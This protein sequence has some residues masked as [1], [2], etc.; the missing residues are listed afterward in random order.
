MRLP[1]LGGKYA[2]QKYC[3]LTHH[4][5]HLENILLLETQT[6][7]TESQRYWQYIIDSKRY[8]VPDCLGFVPVI[9]DFGIANR[10]EMC[11]NESFTHVHPIEENDRV[12]ADVMHFLSILKEMRDLGEISIPDTSWSRYATLLR[13]KTFSLALAIPFLFERQFLRKPPADAVQM[14]QRMI[15]M[16][17]I[18]PSDHSL[19]TFFLR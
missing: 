17:S 11:T 8:Y 19:A 12:C 10:P 3:A 1:H 18:A 14:S 15:S 7:N 13:K 2:L 6:N 16:R 9:W 5:L 4:D